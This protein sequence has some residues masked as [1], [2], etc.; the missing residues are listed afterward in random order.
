MPLLNLQE[1]TGDVQDTGDAKSK[2]SKTSFI[3]YAFYVAIVFI[4]GEFIW[5]TNA[6]EMGIKDCQVNKQVEIREAVDTWRDRYLTERVW[7]IGDLHRKDSII[8]AKQAEIRM[9]DS[10][11]TDKYKTIFDLINVRQNGST[12]KITRP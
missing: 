3:A 12:I 2:V 11:I 1:P 5:A 7:H 6:Y 9:K 10:I 8:A 4:V